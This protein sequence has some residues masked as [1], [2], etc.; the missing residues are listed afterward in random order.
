[1]ILEL[2]SEKILIRL[3]LF[4]CKAFIFLIKTVHITVY[5]KFFEK[6]LRLKHNSG[7]FAFKTC[8]IYVFLGLFSELLSKILSK[9]FDGF[10]NLTKR[11]FT[12]RTLWP[13][14]G[15]FSTV[16]ETKFES[17]HF[18][19]VERLILYL[20]LVHNLEDTEK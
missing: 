3:E 13:L 11:S 9:F 20:Y 2:D 18:E 4:R 7:D 14:S 5:S 8:L 19:G 1:M 17:K 12:L 16:C 15:T 10:K 6:Y